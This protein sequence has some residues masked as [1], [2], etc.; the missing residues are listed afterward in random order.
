[1]EKFHQEAN[2][3]NNKV[4]LVDEELDFS[5][6]EFLYKQHNVIGI[7]IAQLYES[8]P[9]NQLE[10]QRLKKAKLFLKD[11]ILKLK[12]NSHPDIIA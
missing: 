4:E 7:R 6:L 9:P 5:N 2:N 3:N 1:M 10:I 12:S 11:I 8:I